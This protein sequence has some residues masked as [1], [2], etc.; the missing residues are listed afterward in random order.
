[1]IGEILNSI[2][3][4]WSSM[5]NSQTAKWN[6]D[7]TISAQKEMAELEWKKNLDAWK[8]QNEYNSPKSQMLRFSE[9]GLN[10]RLMYGSGSAG[11]GTASQIGRYQ[12]PRPEYNYKPPI[13]FH[14]AFSAFQDFRLKKAQIN[15]IEAQ[16]NQKIQSTITE[17]INQALKSFALTSQKELFPLKRDL[18]DYQGTKMKFG[19]ENEYTKG[20]IYKHQADMLGIKKNYMD[21]LL[22][23]QLSIL[24]KNLLL[25][26]QR[27]KNMVQ[28]ELIKKSTVK[29]SD[30]N[31]ISGL[32]NQGLGTIGKFVLPKFMKSPAVKAGIGRY[33]PNY[34]MYPNKNF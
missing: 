17:Q 7:R 31:Q 11:A 33:N 26:D 21:S 29:Y 2:G 4:V 27:Q 32:I 5:L 28:D 9:A 13:D 1:M 24:N 23:G 12:A 20:F 34:G 14:G 30:W 16:T 18:L 22:Q 15:N 10:P 8:M 25:M 3:N 6:T 19:A